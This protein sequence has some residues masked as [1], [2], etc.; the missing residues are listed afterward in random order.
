MLRVIPKYGALSWILQ[1]RGNAF[2]SVSSCYLAVSSIP[3]STTPDRDSHPTSSMPCQPGELRADQLLSKLWRQSNIRTKM[4]FRYA[5]KDDIKYLVKMTQEYNWWYSEFEYNILLDLDPCSLT[6]ATNKCNI[7]IGFMG[8]C[9]ILPEITYNG[10]FIVR[11]DYRGSGI[12]KIFNKAMVLLQT[13]SNGCMDLDHNFVDHYSK[14][15]FIY[16]SYK[17]NCF[18]GIVNDNCRSKSKAQGTCNIAII[19]NNELPLVLE[20]DRSVYKGLDRERILRACLFDENVVSVISLCDGQTT[21]YGSLIKCAKT[22]KYSI[23]SL[24]AD[25]DFVV[26]EILEQMLKVVPNGANLTIQLMA[27]KQLSERFSQFKFSFQMQRVFNKHLVEADLKRMYFVNDF[28][29]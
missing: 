28:M 1:A 11:K 6:V 10:P 20:Y 9:R 24:F 4:N 15:G 22:N 12:G 5:V 2:S 8:I 21:G 27:D 17:F 19:S 26:E 3:Y 14:K 13:D 25:D 7:P 16:K 23:A 29:F 18:Q